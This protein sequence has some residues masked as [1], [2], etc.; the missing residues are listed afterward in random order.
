M[1][2]D[3]RLVCMFSSVGAYFLVRFLGAPVLASIGVALFPCAVIWVTRIRGG[4]PRDP[5]AAA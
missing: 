4:R 1:R 2:V 3:W 5:N